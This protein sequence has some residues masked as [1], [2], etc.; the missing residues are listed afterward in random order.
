V[1]V[2][3]R[4]LPA[5]DPAA[6]LVGAGMLGLS[7]TAS[8]AT[9]AEVHPTT[10]QAVSPAPQTCRKFWHNGGWAWRD[11]GRWDNRHHWQSHRERYQRGRWFGC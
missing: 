8:A 5:A 11:R 4:D 9:T 2:V 10:S 1:A 7:G 6:A 3:V